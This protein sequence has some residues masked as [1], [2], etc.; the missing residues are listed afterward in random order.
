[1]VTKNSSQPD[2]DFWRGK[3]VAL[4]GHTGFKG[5]WMALLL[6]RLGALVYGYA[7]A[8]NTQ[9]SLFEVAK[10]AQEIAS[11]VDDIRDD[12]S[13]NRWMTS[14]QPEVVLHFAAQALVRESYRDPVG[15]MTSNFVGTLNLLEAIRHQASV[16]TVVVVTT[17][18]V[19]RN[20]ESAKSF[21]EDDH[22]G[23][24][25]PY[26]ASKAACEIL[27]DSYRKCFLSHI[28][29]A[30]A[31]A[32]NVI[33]GGDWSKERLI[34]DAVRAWESG[35]VLEIRSPAAVRPWQHVLEPLCA[36]LILAQN[37]WSDIDL[38]RAYNFGPAVTDAVSVKQVIELAQTAYGKGTV[39]FG[40]EQ[41]GL[42]EAGLLH[43]NTQLV[44][45][46]LGLVPRW[47]LACA[48][49]KTM[50]WYRA[51][52]VGED[53]RSLCLRDIEAYLGA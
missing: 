15:T 32:G 38:A 13:L 4:T 48:V 20:D 17:D 43:L 37:M 14:V 52:G 22:L 7:L 33:G 41:N 44:S 42:H 2:P 46:V 6:K 49:E 24:H 39:Q 53:A 40:G 27:V 3:R 29:L 21:Q 10:V 1:M 18:K 25:D 36:Y 34:P 11:H 45:E 12:Y 9:P 35:Q 28:G 31:R 26:S 19:Y 47:N 8:P 51:Y 30:T 50:A 23:G 5:A 16:K